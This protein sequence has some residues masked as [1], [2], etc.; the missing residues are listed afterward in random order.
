M[1]ISPLSFSGVSTFS[2]DFQTILTRSAQI[3][4]L[5]VQQLQN[6]D[7]DVLSR[8]TQLGA[9]GAAAT[10]FATSFTGLLSLASSQ[11]INATSSDSTVVSA[12]ATGAV[13]GGSYTINH[14]TSLATAAGERSA[15]GYADSTSAPVSSTGVV[16]L[17]FGSNEYTINLTP[18]TN[19]LAGLQN[20]INSLGV[21][22][23][24]SILTSGTG[25]NPNY[26]SLSSSHTGATTLRLIDDPAGSNSNLLTSANQ[27][28]D[29]VFQLN[30][31]PITR[32]NNVVND[33][34]PGVTFTLQKPT[35]TAVTLS[36]AT[37]RSQLATALQ[38]FVSTY[39][40]L[41]TQVK[42]QV[43]P[44]AGLLS[45]DYAIRQIQTDLRQ[46]TSYQGSTGS[47]RS[48]ASLGIEFSNTGQASFNSNTFSALTDNQITDSFHFLGSSTGGL[49]QL[50]KTFNQ[51]TDPISG[52]IK[53]ELDSLDVTDRGLQA[54]VATLTA[55]IA[56]SQT[57]LQR[58]LQ[59]ADGLLASLQSQQKIIQATATSLLAQINGTN[60]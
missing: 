26:L 23:S 29:A 40:A 57:A 1:A 25:S 42:G 58:R 3:A 20:A 24:A 33:V 28:T 53:N 2:D 32:S 47:I 45:G 51:L 5:P 8:K 13:A 18:Q 30:G 4:N 22:V 52:L 31:I 49:G 56:V 36:L 16:K 35:D 12:I 59:A 11:A 17:V 14:V 55:R 46:L 10:A 44:N 43:G 7:S 54:K 6:R 21:G 41:T 9:V 39:N 27:G 50:G 19:N 15:V 60:K 38:S 48:L 37:D 34:V